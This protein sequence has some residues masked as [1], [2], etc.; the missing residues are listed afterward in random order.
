MVVEEEEEEEE[1][2]EDEEEEEEEEE[3]DFLL[4]LTKTPF[5]NWVSALLLQMLLLMLRVVTVDVDSSFIS[6]CRFVEWS[7]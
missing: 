1:E 6:D 2:K 7:V 5:Y 3:E 4:P